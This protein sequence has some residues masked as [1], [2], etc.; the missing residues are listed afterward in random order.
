MNH[1]KDYN[2][3]KV[4][5]SRKFAETLEVMSMMRGGGFAHVV[6]YQPSTDYVE[7][8]LV[9]ITF[10]S[11]FST[12]KLYERKSVALKN[13][14]FSDITVKGDKLESLDG[15][16]QKT[17]F[18]DCVAKMVGSMQKTL[19]GD[20]SDAHRQGHDRCYIVTSQGI[21]IHLDTVKG[22]DGHM[23]PVLTDGHPTAKSIMVPMIETMR[24]TVKEGVKKT[25]KNG[26][27][28]QM[29]KCIERSLNARSVSYRTLS[30]KEDNF[31]TLKMDGEEFTVANIFSQVRDTVRLIDTK[32]LA[33]IIET[34]EKE[35]V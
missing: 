30:L 13:L 9:N 28:V 14:T 5:I 31:K 32:D 2:G 12:A 6:E 3:N 26:A 19:D 24:S 16:A 1:L 35:T 34:E 15:D 21:K 4:W 10:I 20:R 18:A 29:D 7:K 22:P 11:K 33:E 27:K 23:I 17:L 8:P 25:V